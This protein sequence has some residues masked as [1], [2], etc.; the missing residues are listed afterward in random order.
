MAT[1]AAENP[2]SAALPSRALQ[3]SLRGLLALFV[4][5]AYLAFRTAEW[6]W[7]FGWAATGCLAAA[8]LAVWSLYYRRWLAL[9]GVLPVALL[10]IVPVVLVNNAPFNESDQRCEYCG[11]E[12]HVSERWLMPVRVTQRETDESRWANQVGLKETQHRFRGLS[13]H[14]RSQWFG[15][16]LIACGMFAPVSSIHYSRQYLGEDACAQHLRDHQALLDQNNS[17]AARTLVEKVIADAEQVRQDRQAQALQQN[18]SA[19]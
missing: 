3:F 9:A 14:T 10:G 8:A 2:R 6:G 13:S 5:A 12:Q 15:G 11:L 4:V 18:A 19:P 17:A 7:L 1:Q 16:T